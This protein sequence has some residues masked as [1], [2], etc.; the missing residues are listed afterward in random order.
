MTDRRTIWAPHG[1]LTNRRSPSRRPTRTKRVVQLEFP[2]LQAANS[3]SGW[4]WI[5]GTWLASSNK[6]PSSEHYLIWS[7]KM[8]LNQNVRIGTSVTCFLSRSM[9]S[10]PLTVHRTERKCWLLIY[11]KVLRSQS[12]NRPILR[13]ECSLARLQIWNREAHPNPR[14]WSRKER[15]WQNWNNSQVRSRILKRTGLIIIWKQRW[16][17]E[18]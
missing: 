5:R 15:K 11:S 2:S 10:P 14:K 6:L 7:N 8:I 3:T 12:V 17:S 9:T 1:R 13:I 16:V 18:Y 4:V